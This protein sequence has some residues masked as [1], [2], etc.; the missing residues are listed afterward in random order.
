[1]TGLEFAALLSALCFVESSHRVN[2]VHYDDGGSSSLGYCQIKLKTA[3][4]LG[5]KG[6]ITNLWLNKETNKHWAGTYLRYQLKR[7]K[8]DIKKAVSAYNCGRACGNTLY[9]DKVMKA[10]KEK[11]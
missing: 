1:M 8:G 9:V 3:R 7:Y 4:W 11:R 6:S 5:Y 2:A 10:W